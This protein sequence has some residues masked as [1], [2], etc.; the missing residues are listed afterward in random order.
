MRDRIFTWIMTHE[1]AFQALAVLALSI[2]LLVLTAL[3][4][5][6]V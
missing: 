1:L 6:T 2:G 3:V 5:V 4:W